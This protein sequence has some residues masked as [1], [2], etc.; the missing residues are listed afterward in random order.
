MNR[1]DDEPDFTNEEPDFEGNGACDD[2]RE[3]VTVLLWSIRQGWAEPGDL[4]KAAQE[5]DIEWPDEDEDSVLEEET[6]Q[7]RAMRVL[8]PETWLV[9]EWAKAYDEDPQS[10]LD[11]FSGVSISASDA[12][13]A[14]EYDSWSN[15]YDQE[16]ESLLGKL[17]KVSTSDG[18]GTEPREHDWWG[19]GYD[20]ELEFLLDKF[21]GV[22]SGTSDGEEAEEY[23]W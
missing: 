22:S 6:E 15:G 20:Q 17:S 21:S 12:A 11:K 16:F 5:F 4:I 2:H 18:T 3:L 7:E 8:C 10:L 1:V 14:E 23:D 19:N 9:Y 13:E